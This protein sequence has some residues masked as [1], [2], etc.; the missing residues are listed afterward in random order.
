MLDILLVNAFTPKSQTPEDEAKRHRQEAMRAVCLLAIIVAT[1][2]AIVT[3]VRHRASSGSYSADLVLSVF[4]P[5]TY[6][7]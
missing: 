3:A 4:A 7:I 6:W 1:V 2:L 5:I